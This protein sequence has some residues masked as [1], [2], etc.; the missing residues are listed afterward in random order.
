MAKAGDQLREE[1]IK[2]G[3]RMVVSGDGAVITEW[4]ASKLHKVQ[5][6]ASGWRVLYQHR[7]TGQFWELSY[8]M[9]QMH[10][11]GPRLLTCLPITNLSEWN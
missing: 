9:S 4:L 10:G 11:G 2:A 5:T 6:D 3:D 7:E 1:W 8:P